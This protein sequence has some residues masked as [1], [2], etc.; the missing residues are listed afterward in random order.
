M[1]ESE[2]ER[3]HHQHHRGDESMK[4]IAFHATRTMS[5]TRAGSTKP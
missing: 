5:G 2:N 3:E 1:T 4:L